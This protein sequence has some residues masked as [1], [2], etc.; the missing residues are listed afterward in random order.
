M[1]V[2]IL[3]DVHLGFGRGSEREGDAYEALAEALEKSRDSDLILIAGDIFDSN[4]PPAEV[5][6]LSE[7]ILLPFLLEDGGMRIPEG[8]EK[9]TKK[10]KLVN[11]RRPIIAIHGTHERRARGLLNPVQA[12]ERAGFLVYLHCNGI[13]LEKGGEKI[14]V[15][16]M[17]GVPDQYSE[18][19]LQEWNPRPR[20]GC[21][22]TLMIHQNLRG[23]MHEKVP[24]QMDPEKLNRGFDL[25]VCGH[26]HSGGESELGGSKLVIPGGMV[27]TQIREGEKPL[28]FFKMDTSSGKAGFVE[29]ESQRNIYFLDAGSREEGER[30][31][32]E[33]LEKRHDRKPIIR[34]DIKGDFPLGGLKE[35]FGD[36][37]ILNF[38]KESGAVEGG[39]AVGMEEQR[40]SVRDLGKK[41]LRENLERQ[42]L[43][44]DLFEQVFELLLEKRQEKALE[45]LREGGNEAGKPV[46]SG[47]I[48]RKRKPK[49]E[50]TGKWEGKGE[51][52]RFFG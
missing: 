42:G 39:G 9:D 3:S 14:C 33:I 11:P 24:N 26:I 19:V 35:R 25:Y 34:V 21:Y 17:S 7:E 52:G 45:L 40:L 49:G 2:S 38:R 18:R 43:E 16:G 41:L 12:L 31:V 51:L 29:L 50:E 20:E 6:A 13:I 27:T 28:G 15:Q 46:E 47:K 48:E 30:G 36:R 8:M 32:R 1:K 10:L 5:L 22:N 37:A 23:F 44:P 4:N